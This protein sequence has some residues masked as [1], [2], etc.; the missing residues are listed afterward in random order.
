MPSRPRPPGRTRRPSAAP[1]T[2]DLAGDNSLLDLVDNALNH[3]VVVHGDLVIG[4]AGVDLIYAR[5]SLLLAAV[6]KVQF[7]AAVRKRR[8]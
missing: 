6:D 4:V 2:L 5:L 1:R 8:S 7:R 3:G